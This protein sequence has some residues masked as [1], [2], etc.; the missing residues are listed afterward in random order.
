MSVSDKIPVI[1][2]TGFLGSGKTTLLRR[3]AED[4]PDWRLVFLVNEFAETSVD[5]ETLAA[6]GSP[7]QSVVGGSLF[8]ECKA[9]DFLRTMREEVL[10][11][12]RESPLDSVVIE[13]SG[14]ADPEAIGQLM[15]AHGLASAFELRSIVTVVAPVR[16]AKLLGNLPIVEAQLRASDLIVINKTDTVDPGA[17]DEAET[18]IRQHNAKARIVR[19]E[20]CRFDFLLS[21]TRPVAPSGDL[22]TC[23]ANPFSTAETEWPE[24]RPVAEAREWI[25]S[26]PE[27]ILRIKGCLRTPEGYWHVERTVDSFTLE[28][29]N[30]GPCKLV[31]IA[32]DDDTEDL[33]A[34]AR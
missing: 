15:A 8:C 30:P 7:T 3:L 32:H 19:A 25:A 6:T 27:T 31:L 34:G 5:G 20:Y 11:H 28:P 10:G 2:V 18:A 9:G 13:T 4:H 22:S 23:E 17:L 12:H 16:L 29:T 33:A 24:D 14:T 1:L 21:E 26:L